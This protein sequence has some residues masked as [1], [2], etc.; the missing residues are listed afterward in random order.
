[1]HFP[2]GEGSSW[3]LTT[4]SVD[5]HQTSAHGSNVPMLPMKPSAR[6]QDEHAQQAAFATHG[7]IPKLT[8]RLRPNGGEVT[9]KC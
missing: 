2:G 9:G 1:M 5:Q 6:G 3:S 4:T 8:M 7:P